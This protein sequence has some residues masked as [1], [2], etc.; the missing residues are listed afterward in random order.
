MSLAI[1]PAAAVLAPGVPQPFSGAG[2]TAPYTF[3]ILSG[4]GALSPSLDADTE[5]Y[6]AP[7]SP[8]V[9]VVRVTDALLATADAQVA[10]GT[11][12]QLLVDILVKE[13]GLAASRVYLWDQKINAP[14]DNDLFIAVSVLNCKPFSNSR[15][16][17]GSGAGLIERQSTNFQ[18]QVSL[19]VISRDL[20]AVNRKEEVLLALNSNYSEQQQE[21]NSF[22]IFPL[23]SAFTNLSGIDGA[24]IPYR[25][26]ISINMQY[27]VV[28]TKSVPYFDTFAA[29]SVST[30]P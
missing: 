6:T 7:A 15:E 11:P 21:L 22:R 29:P 9:A 5:L 4:G 17:D 24:A 8:G 20:S 13:M 10:I 1:L 27:A 19:D 18:A 25:F 12:L 16:L 23:S 28:K 30:D 26:S 3:T 14:T 2:G